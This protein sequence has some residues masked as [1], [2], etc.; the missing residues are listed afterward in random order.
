[1]LY[2]ITQILIGLLVLM[3]I[4]GLFCLGLRLLTKRVMRKRINP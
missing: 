2:T 3:G 1:M 4:V